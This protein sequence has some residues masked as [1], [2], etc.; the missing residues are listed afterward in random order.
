MSTLNQFPISQHHIDM[1]TSNVEA[2]IQLLPKGLER[3]V[4]V[5]SYT[6]EQAQVVNF[7]GTVDFTEMTTR[8]SDTELSELSHTQRWIYPKDFDAGVMIDR[9]DQLRMLY[10]P[11]SPYVQAVSLG[12]GRKKD[13][14]IRDAF[15]SNGFSGKNGATSVQFDTNN[16]IDVTVGSSATPAVATG[17]NIDK[18]RAAR[19]KIKQNTKADGPMDEEIFMG[20]TAE[21]IDDLLGIK[22]IQSSDFAATKALVNGEVSRFLGI[23]FVP[24]EG[25]GTRDDS[26]DTI[27]ELPVWVR[28]GMHWG[29][30]EAG[31]SIVISPRPDKRNLPQIHANFT[32]NA[33]RIREEKVLRVD[34]LE[35]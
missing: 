21:Q 17:L 30:W 10:D 25:W 7:V 28:S 15:F 29:N 32:A 16:V 2:D 1:F 8:Y 20:V 19:K 35:P 27:R 11:T 26:G 6:G 3:F 31:P 14:L 12:F 33:V 9:I 18:L 22:E 34:C 5:G 23:T 4:T 13:E 24:W